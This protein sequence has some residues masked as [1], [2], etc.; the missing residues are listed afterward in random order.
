ME[1][2]SMCKAYIKSQVYTFFIVKYLVLFRSVPF[3]NPVWP[4]SGSFV[5]IKRC[6]GSFLAIVIHAF[7]CKE[8]YNT[9]RIA[10]KVKQKYDGNK[11]AFLWSCLL[12]KQIENIVSNNNHILRTFVTETLMLGSC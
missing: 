12:N 11:F 1:M 8:K 9:H 4:Q 7:N 10:A 6:S 3:I 5:H 2:H